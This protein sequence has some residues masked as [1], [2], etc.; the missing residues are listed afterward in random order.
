MRWWLCSFFMTE[1]VKMGDDAWRMFAELCQI[2]CEN[3]NV[4]LDVIV[5]NGC[6]EFMLMPIEEDDEDD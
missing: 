4:F 1:E 6:I 5:S 2:V 3:E